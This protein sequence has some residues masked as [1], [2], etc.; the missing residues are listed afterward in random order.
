MVVKPSQGLNIFIDFQ[1]EASL[2]Q[3]VVEIQGIIY[4]SEQ[5]S[6]LLFTSITQMRTFFKN[7]SILFYNLTNLKPK[8]VV[9]FFNFVKTS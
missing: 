3:D 8:Y 7:I 9:F 6:K 2:L 1:S 4:C 5:T